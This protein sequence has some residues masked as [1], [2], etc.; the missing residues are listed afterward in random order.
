MTVD[1]EPLLERAVRETL[2]AVLSPAVRDA[3][4]AEALAAARAQ[5]VPKEP[6]RFRV[7]VA[8]PLR[9]GLIRALGAELG[10]S[11]VAELDRVADHVE[12]RPLSGR[13]TQNGALRGGSVTAQRRRNSPRPRS[14]WPPSVADS[15]STWRQRGDAYP[16]SAPRNPTPPT[17]RPPSGDPNRDTKTP[18]AIPPARRS[19]LPRSEIFDRPA[20]PPSAP[21]SRSDAPVSSQQYRAMEAMGSIRSAR[22]PTLT[23]GRRTL[24][25]QIPRPPSSDQLPRGTAE[26]LGLAGAT[27]SDRPA[28]LAPYVLVATRDATLG[29]KLSQWIGKSVAV[30]R[31]RSVM[32]LAKDLD[33]LGTS[34]VVIV[35]DCNQPSIRPSALAALADDLP[36]GT[37]VVLWGATAEIRRELRIV[38]PRTN[39][40]LEVDAGASARDVAGRCADLVS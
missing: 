29:R 11:V 25:S 17:I 24:S 35:L 2:D 3:L 19:G 33:S 13:R 26:T 1:A 18:R 12:G 4:L 36:F 27:P 5:E 20:T 8:G 6:E 21:A 9:T 28:A 7:F 39:E 23:S 16:D 32:A 38:S 30:M 34:R 10:E 14:A 40:W 37:R 15:P 22:V 31:V